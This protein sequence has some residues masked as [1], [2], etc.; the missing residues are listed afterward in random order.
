MAALAS[1]MLQGRA[2]ATGGNLAAQL[3]QQLQSVQHTAPTT[4]A[5]DAQLLS[6]LTQA[7]NANTIPRSPSVCGGGLHTALL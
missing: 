5:H 4:S 1:P 6:A 3:L 2:P 7:L